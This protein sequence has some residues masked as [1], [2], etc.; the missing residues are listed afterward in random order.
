[1]ERKKT[2][3]FPPAVLQLFDGCVH[4]RLEAAAKLSWQ[5]SLGHFNRHL[6]A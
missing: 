5:R 6:H 2:S 1:M 4:G 3:D